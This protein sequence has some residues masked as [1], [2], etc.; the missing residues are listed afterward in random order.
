MLRDFARDQR[1]WGEFPAKILAHAPRMQLHYLDLPGV[2]TEYRRP[3]PSSITAIRIEL[4]QRFHG[5]VDRGKLPAGPWSILA[6]SLGGMVA[7]DW[8]YAEPELFARAVIVNSSSADVASP[9]E[10]FDPRFFP[11]ALLTFIRNRPEDFEGF[12]FRAAS[13]RFARKKSE[14]DPQVQALYENLV[15]LRR[16][17]PVRRSTLVNQ[18]LAAARFAVPAGRPKAKVVFVSGEGDRVVSPKCSLR[19]AERL[20][21]PRLVHPWAGHD[22]PT[23]DPEW[24]A[25]EVTDWMERPS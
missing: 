7:L 14:R 12:F 17:R 3:S 11:G 1:T 22:I 23:D 25:R 13:N 20:G 19:L 18:F 4:A 2:G 8:I 24:L 16:E 10:R 9:L 6:V 15:R 21:A 5:L